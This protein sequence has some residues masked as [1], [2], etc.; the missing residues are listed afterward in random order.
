MSNL[1]DG[2]W[3]IPCFVVRVK[4]ADTIVVD[5]DLGWG[6]WKKNLAVRIDG[7]WSPENSTPEGKVATE[8]AK[9]ILPIGTRVTLHSR[10]VISFERVVG[11]LYLMYKMNEKEYASIIVENGYGEIR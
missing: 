5:G 2:I 9:S 10:W 8:F 4:D 7:L 3:R 6:V 11:S 1:H